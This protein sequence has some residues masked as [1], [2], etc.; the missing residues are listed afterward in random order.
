MDIS[1]IEI[2]L[3]ISNTGGLSRSCE[4]LHMSQPTLSKKLARIED[5]LGA[6]LFYRYPKGLVPTDIAKYILTKF[7][8]LREQLSEIERHVVMMNELEYGQLNLGVGPIIEQIL[9]PNVLA[10]FV[11]STNG[12]QI[13]VVTEDD[14]TLLEMFAASELDIIVGPFQAEDWQR[15]DIMSIPM[16]EDEIIAIART[17]HPIFGKNKITEKQ[18]LEYPLIAPKAQGTARDSQVTPIADALKVTSDNYDLLKKVTLT[19]DTICAGPRAVF[20][21]EINGGQLRETGVALSISWKSAL[22]VR[23]ETYVTPLAHL[24]VSLFEDAASAT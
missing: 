20:Q 7:P 22:L 5:R 8:P 3:T 19:T 17:N 2:I 14:E 15:V 23:P 4:H 9:L 11:E 13:S 12:P 21:N 1:D 18:L 6:Q 24:V 10:K 16:I